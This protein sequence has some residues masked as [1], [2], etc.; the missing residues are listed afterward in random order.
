MF[1]VFKK[2]AT[3]GDGPAGGAG[4]GTSAVPGSVGQQMSD[5]LKKKFSR[6]VQYNSEY[7]IHYIGMK[8]GAFGSLNSKVTGNV[9]L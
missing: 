6:G 3:K 7:Y 2:L 1:S 9:F 4:G 5:S 8:L